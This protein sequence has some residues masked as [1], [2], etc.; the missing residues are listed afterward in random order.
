MR[1]A[2]TSSAGVPPSPRLLPGRPARNGSPTSWTWNPAEPGLA[3][4]R[5]GEAGK[6]LLKEHESTLR[7]LAMDLSAPYRSTAPAGVTVIAS[8]LDGDGDG[9]QIAAVWIAKEH[10]RRLLALRAAR[11]R[12][13]P[14][15]SAV[16]DRPAASAWPP[17]AVPA[18]ASRTKTTPVTHSHRP[19]QSSITISNM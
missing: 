6:S 1:Q 17:P 19:S 8:T 11:T 5:T 10:L 15:P 13:T 18:S 16:R 7:Y 14:A 4:E 3:Q 2:S 9:Q 12:I